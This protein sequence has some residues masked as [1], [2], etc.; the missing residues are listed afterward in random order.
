[1]CRFLVNPHRRPF[2]EPDVLIQSDIAAPEIVDFHKSIRGYAPTPLVEL[3]ALAAELDLGGIVVKDESPRFGLQAFKSLGASYAIFRFFKAGLEAQGVPVNDF[4]ELQS[5]A[6]AGLLGSIPL[7]TA[8]DGNH[9]RAVA[10]VAAMLG[11]PAF[12]YMPQNS[13]PARVENIR[14]EGATVTLVK[15]GFDE[16]V[17]QAAEDAH[18]NGWQVISDTGYADYQ[19]IP[20]W[21]S[22]GYQTMFQEISEDLEVSG[23]ASP[24]VLIVQ[25][26]VGALVAGTVLFYRSACQNESVKL[27]CVEPCDADCLFESA[28]SPD[29]EPRSARGSIDS[30]MAGLNCATPSLTAWPIIRNGADA[31][32]SISD[33]YAEEA[34]KLYYSPRGGD[35]RIIS[36]ESGAAGLAGLLAIL[37]D[38]TLTHVRETLGLGRSSRILVINTEGATDPEGFHRITGGNP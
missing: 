9:G 25:G 5:W 22:L 1:M 36:G 17:R 26:G 3:T 27:V 16:A 35:L 8:T 18:N 23:E 4:R 7:C 2:V 33:R 30:I 15:G 10:W 31:F 11:L 34:M 19:E 6:K 28:A 13:V 12:I 14:Q 20:Q 24:D 37:N 32:L 21:V 29:G 38:A